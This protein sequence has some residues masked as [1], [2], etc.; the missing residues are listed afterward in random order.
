MSEN[1]WTIGFDIGQVRDPSA[2]D[3]RAE[4]AVDRDLAVART[5][6]PRSLEP[7]RVVQRRARRQPVGRAAVVGTIACDALDSFR[8]AP[9][10][11]SSDA[12]PVTNGALNDVPH[13]AA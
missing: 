8:L 2:L 3:R 6:Y 4:D 1:I 9:A 10:L 13:V 11:K 7:V 5:G 12:P